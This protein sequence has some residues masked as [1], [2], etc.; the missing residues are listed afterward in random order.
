MIE[1]NPHISKVRRYEWQPP[2]E[3]YEAW[4]FEDACK[5]ARFLAKQNNSIQYITEEYGFRDNKLIGL[6]M[7]FDETYIERIYERQDSLLGN[8]GFMKGAVVTVVNPDEPEVQQ[9]SE[10]ELREWLS[11]NQDT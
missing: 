10:N 3:A 4:A 11:K 9:I 6:F 1:I 5:N 7:I 2:G 8:G